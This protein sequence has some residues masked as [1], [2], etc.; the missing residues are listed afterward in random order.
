MGE[1]VAAWAD[2]AALDMGGPEYERMGKICPP[3]GDLPRR[4]RL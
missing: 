4:Q 3:A 2:K 1:S